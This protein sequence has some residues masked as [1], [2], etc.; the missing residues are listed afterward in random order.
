MAISKKRKNVKVI[1]KPKIKQGDEVVV[2]VGDNEGKKGEVLLVDKSSAS[3]LVKGVNMVRKTMQKSQENQQGGITEQEGAISLS[4]VAYVS[5]KDG[6]ATKI[7]R[8]L[9]DGKL[10]RYEKRTGEIIDK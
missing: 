6:K 7:G 8:K 2:L 9:V 4:N 10:K 5:K 3:V 1:D